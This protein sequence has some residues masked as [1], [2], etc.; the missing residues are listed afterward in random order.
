MRAL[1]ALVMPA[2][3]IVITLDTVPLLVVAVVVEGALAPTQHA[4]EYEH[5]ANASTFEVLRRKC[6]SRRA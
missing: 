2:M 1:V 5:M 6:T 4:F 3:L